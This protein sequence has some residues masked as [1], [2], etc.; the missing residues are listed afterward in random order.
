[1]DLVDFL[2]ARLAEDERLAKA[3]ISDARTPPNWRGV[4]GP[5]RWIT[6]GPVVVGDDMTI[7]DE[8]GH[9]E[10]QAEHIAR[11]DP[12]HVLADVE[13]R[14][15]IV[16]HCS[17]TIGAAGEPP[18]IDHDDIPAIERVLRLLALPHADRPGYRA[19]W[20]P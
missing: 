13:A 19:E 8:G 20:K 11:H 7:Y 17:A 14:R 18:G 2:R 6:D 10:A 12:A 3:A 1:M 4:Q 5:G 9:D 15:R 16:E